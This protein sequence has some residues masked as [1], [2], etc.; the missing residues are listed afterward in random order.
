MDDREFLDALYKS[1]AQTSSQ[2]PNVVWQ[3]DGAD[4]VEVD[5]NTNEKV[6]TVARLLLEEDADFICN[7]HGALPHLVK[8][9]LEA[10]DEAERAEYDKDSRECRIAELEAEVMRYERHGW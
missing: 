9:C 6:G 3:P 7:V 2:N 10:F 1:W 8:V 4:I 5:L